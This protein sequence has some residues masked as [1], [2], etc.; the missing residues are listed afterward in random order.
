MVHSI[1]EVYYEGGKN[2]YHVEKL[3]KQLWRRELAKENGKKIQEE[4]E[5]LIE[6]V[7]EQN[8]QRI[9]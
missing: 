9:Y 4:R 5:E 2:V 7:K 3:E 1:C 8:Y 6:Y